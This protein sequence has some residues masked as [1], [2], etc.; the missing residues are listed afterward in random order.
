MLESTGQLT[1]TALNLGIRQ[2]DPAAYYNLA[3]EA[4]LATS[5]QGRA[6]D[7]IMKSL[8]KE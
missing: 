2:Y 1:A 7:R 8:Q 4:P 5:E 3:K 6:L